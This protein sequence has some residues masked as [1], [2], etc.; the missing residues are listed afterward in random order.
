MHEALHWILTYFINSVWITALV[1]LAAVLA[2][3]LMRRIS[4]AA[5]HRIWVAALLLSILLPALSASRR[6]TDADT[7]AAQLQTLPIDTVEAGLAKPPAPA[8]LLRTYSSRLLL[9]ENWEWFVIASYL[10]FVL[11]RSVRV[12][13]AWACTRSLI[14]HASAITLPH[15]IEEWWTRYKKSFHVGDVCLYESAEISSPVTAG[16]LKPALLLPANFLSNKESTE[17]N[18]ALCHELAHMQRRDFL[19]NLLYEI[20]ALPIAYHPAAK[21]LKVRIDE[22]REILCDEMAAAR[23]AGPKTYAGA[24]LRLAQRMTA[25]AE[26][27]PTTHALG[28]FEANILEKRIMYLLEKKSLLNRK[29]QAVVVFAGIATLTLTCAAATLYN[30]QVATPLPAQTEQS[31]PTQGISNPSQA[32]P[33]TNTP[34]EE[35]SAPAKPSRLRTDKQAV[36]LRHAMKE[37]KKQLQEQEKAIEQ[38]SKEMQKQIKMQVDAQFN[39]A[40]FREQ[41][42]EAQKQAAK[43]RAFINSPEFHQ[44]MEDARQQEQSAAKVFNSPEFKAQLAKAQEQAEAARKLL[45]SP[46]FQAQ[47][48]Y[49][50]K[51]AELASR[52]IVNNPELQKQMQELKEQLDQLRQKNPNLS[53]HTP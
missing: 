35:L 19:L 50:S 14:R 37:Q 46:E 31:T 7:T 4:W 41:M 21:F 30:V 24:L 11:Y 10:S 1:S 20:V 5:E 47:L 26:T 22:S 16:S 52:Q 42:K 3:K 44:Q 53:P 49:A 29:L 13:G 27:A 38:Q 25:V 2:A 45:Q 40:A 43:A 17:I 6:A 36:A 48:A 15:E 39:S 12:V 33:T 9:A 51:S 32:E 23:L 34:A 8:I 18:V 28:L